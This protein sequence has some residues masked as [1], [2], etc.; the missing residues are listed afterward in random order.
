MSEGQEPPTANDA[1]LE[2]NK[3]SLNE[4][5]PSRYDVD[6]NPTM[7]NLPAQPTTTRPISNEGR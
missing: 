1:A 4:P 7:P 2:Q 3:V 6:D 5:F